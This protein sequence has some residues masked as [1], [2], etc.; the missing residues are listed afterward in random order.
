MGHGIEAAD[1]W[2]WILAAILL[3]L[4]VIYFVIL[5]VDGWLSLKHWSASR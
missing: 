5:F 4:L 2:P 1:P 3:G